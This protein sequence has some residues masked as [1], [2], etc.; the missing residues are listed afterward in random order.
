[1]DITTNRPR[2]SLIARGFGG[3]DDADIFVSPHVHPAAGNTTKDAA[4]IAVA[5][6]QDLVKR[7]TFSLTPMFSVSSTSSW[8]T[9]NDLDLCN[10]QQF[11]FFA[12]RPP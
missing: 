8:A 7:A 3:A 4:T 6:R 11:L 10:I 5:H 1:M 12:A 2:G 9:G